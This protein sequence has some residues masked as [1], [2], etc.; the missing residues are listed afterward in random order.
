MM[1]AFLKRI[2]LTIKSR[3]LSI[4]IGASGWVLLFSYLA[5]HYKDLR[6]LSE[7]L[8]HLTQTK[9]LIIPLYHMMIL[10][11]PVFS[12][13]FAYMVSKSQESEEKFRTLFDSAGDAIFIHDR[14]GRLLEVN[15]S[16]CELLGYDRSELLQMNVENIEAPDR[17][18]SPQERFEKLRKNE[19]LSFE[20]A[21]IRRDGSR[22]LAETKCKLIE[23]EG[24]PAVLSVAR[25]ITERKRLEENLKRSVEELEAVVE[26]QKNIIERHDLSSLLRFIVSKARELTQADVAFFGFVEGDV[27]RHH[28]FVGTRTRELESI[29]LKKGTGLG[30]LV[31]KERK[32]VVVEDFFTDPRLMNPP[33]EEVKKEGLISF[34]A[35]PFMSGKGEPLGVLYVANRRKSKFTDEHV[36]T[37][38]LLAAQTSVAV[39]HARLYERLKRAYEK[40]QRA[41]KELKSLDELKS[42]IIAN[43]SHELRTPL[44][45]AKGAIELAEMEDDPEERRILLKMAEDALTRQDF[46]VENLI[47]TAKMSRGERRLRFKPVDLATLIRQVAD[48]FTPLLIKNKLTLEINLPENLPKARADGKELRLVMRN[49]LSNAV[50]FN[51]KGGRIIIT[52]EKKGDMLKVCVSDTGIGIPKD[53]LDKIFDAFYQVDSSP[54]RRYG[55]T[56]L[57]LAIVKEVVEAHGGEVEVE[58]EVG[59][60]S[61]FCFTV[62][63]WKHR[64]SETEQHR[65]DR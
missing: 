60:G 9:P 12:T 36:R 61:T 46:I 41:Y 32:P 65:T 37:L 45:I 51:R 22:I 5:Y 2:T 40:L 3:K 52:A 31:L 54:T 18:G 17:I 28:T 11:A 64:R 6:S 4:A 38:V 14:R 35:V 15:R 29:E 25:D 49:L 33:Y 34:L 23:Y 8:L 53:K 42:N 19:E 13:A 21:Y 26:I 57:G 24:S 62:P 58:S 56:G 16:A 30:W 39:E 44:T 27:I 50:K 1:L 7:L 43:V 59:R 63:A 20:A 55:G 48:E 10:L 47:A